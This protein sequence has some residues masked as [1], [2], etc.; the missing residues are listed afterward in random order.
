MKGCNLVN[1]CSE[2]WLSYL[3]NKSL[4]H[5]HIPK[6]LNVIKSTLRNKNIG[7]YLCDSMVETDF[8]DTTLKAHLIKGKT[9]K[10]DCIKI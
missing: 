7:Q 9:D 6:D 2:N 3:K 5:V 1:K 8:L 4:P 10:F